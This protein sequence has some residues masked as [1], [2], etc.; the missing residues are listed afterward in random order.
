MS[1]SVDYSQV[2]AESLTSSRNLKSIAAI[3][4]PTSAPLL[5]ANVRTQPTL[6]FTAT[7]LA[8]LL[9]RMSVNTNKQAATCKISFKKDAEKKAIENVTITSLSNRFVRISMGLCHVLGAVAYALR[10][11]DGHAAPISWALVT[12]QCIVSGVWISSGKNGQ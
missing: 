1:G 2:H 7:A 3:L 5:V 10:S 11:F 6:C 12:G 4:I 9:M 8:I